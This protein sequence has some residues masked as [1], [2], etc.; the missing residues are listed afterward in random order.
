[1]NK[2]AS[3]LYHRKKTMSDSGWTAENKTIDPRK[4]HGALP[5]DKKE[6]KDQDLNYGDPALPPAQHLQVMLL[7][8]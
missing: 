3:I 4:P 2:N 8:L 5:D 6:H 1:M 7:P